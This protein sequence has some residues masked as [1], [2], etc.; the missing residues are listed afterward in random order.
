MLVPAR[1]VHASHDPAALEDLV[2]SVQGPDS[3]DTGQALVVWRAVAK[4][5]GDATVVLKG[6]HAPVLR[7]YYAG[8]QDDF[9]Q[10]MPSES[11]A[12]R[13]DDF[14]YG[15]VSA[16]DWPLVLAPGQ[17]AE[18]E[19]TGLSDYRPGTYR[20]ATLEVLGEVVDEYALKLRHPGGQ[21]RATI[22]GPNQLRLG[23]TETYELKISFSEPTYL[24]TVTFN[25]QGE[26][27]RCRLKIE[28]QPMLRGGAHTSL[29]VRFNVQPWPFVPGE[30]L[31][32]AKCELGGKVFGTTLTGEPVEIPI[33]KEVFKI[34]A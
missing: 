3:E 11:I 18:V 21:P 4:N 19:F 31:L 1:P 17:T 32:G 2:F 25:H 24:G 5:N 14:R 20:V 28:R 23:T 16:Y 9:L 33:R 29:V 15:S 26:D 30:Q 8:L 27:P 22:N 12:F 10:A 7:V 34:I 6:E 13:P